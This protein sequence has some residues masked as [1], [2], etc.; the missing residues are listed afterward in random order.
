MSVIMLS[1]GASLPRG[2]EGLAVSK[3]DCSRYLEYTRLFGALEHTASI[4]DLILN[5]GPDAAKYMKS[6]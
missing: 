1:F 6:D 3:I 2:G 4:I 5:E